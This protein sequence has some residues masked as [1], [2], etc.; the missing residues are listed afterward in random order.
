MNQKKNTKLSKTGWLACVLALVVSAAGLSQASAEQFT[1]TLVNPER[2]GT[3][4]VVVENYSFQPLK[5]LS[6]R[7]K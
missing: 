6:V 1:A 2:G 7:A 3:T 4:P 5:L